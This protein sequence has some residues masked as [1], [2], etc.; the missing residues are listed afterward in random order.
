M[1][2]VYFHPGEGHAEILEQV[3]AEHPDIKFIA[4]G[5]EIRPKIGDLMGRFPNVFF[6]V[7]DHYGDQYLLHQGENTQSF[8]A[9][10]EDVEPLLERDVAKW[11][12]LIEAH[13]DQFLWGTDRGGPAA[14]TFDRAVGQALADYGRAF[15]S[16]LD[17]A[18]QE[19]FAYQ[20]AERLF[21]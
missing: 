4:H 11:K 8:L 19:K 16:R 9:A 6:T 10:L 14:W 1:L 5:P 20:N 7:N 15:I 17:P 21:E 13:P 18:V 2:I 12:D 3:L